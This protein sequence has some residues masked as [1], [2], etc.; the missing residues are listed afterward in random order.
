MEQLDSCEYLFLREISWP[1]HN[2]LHLP[3]EEAKASDIPENIKI[4][5]GR[6]E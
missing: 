2:S 3:I 4:L 6:M 1:R 5:E